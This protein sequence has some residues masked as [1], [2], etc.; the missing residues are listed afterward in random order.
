MK[1]EKLDAI[2]MDAL[3]EKEMASIQGGANS[4]TVGTSG[5]KY[6]S[7]TDRV[8]LVETSGWDSNGNPTKWWS[9]G[10]G[11]YSAS[12]KAFVCD[13]ASGHDVPKL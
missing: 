3:N 11:A 8:T 7:S 9:Y 4:I 6:G 2:N 10:G 5:G 13:Y 12:D 1:F